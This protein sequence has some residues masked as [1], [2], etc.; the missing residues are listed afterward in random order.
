MLLK[1]LLVVLLQLL[2]TVG[3][4]H[5]NSVQIYAYHNAKKSNTQKFRTVSSSPGSD[6]ILRRGNTF[7][8]TAQLDGDYVPG[9]HQLLAQFNFENFPATYKRAIVTVKIT[10]NSRFYQNAQ[11]RPDK[12]HSD[13]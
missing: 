13:L 9:T 6:L 5:V 10:S 1:L 3:A 8:L 2:A 7:T 4:L 11:N 12:W